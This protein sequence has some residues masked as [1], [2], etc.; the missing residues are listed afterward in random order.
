MLGDPEQLG[1]EFQNIGKKPDAR[2]LTRLGALTPHKPPAHTIV[3]S[4]SSSFPAQSSKPEHQKLG[5]NKLRGQF[6]YFDPLTPTNTY[7]AQL[8]MNAQFRSWIFERHRSCQEGQYNPAMR[9]WWPPSYR[10]ARGVSA[11]HGYT[12]AYNALRIS[13]CS[14]KSHANAVVRPRKGRG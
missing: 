3:T 1:A 8:N 5:L 11:A 14:H 13:R 2:K 7:V 4:G 9:W 12:C 10:Y 6:C